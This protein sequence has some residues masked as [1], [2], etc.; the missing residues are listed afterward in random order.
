MLYFK[1][2]IF[3]KIWRLIIEDAERSF[4]RKLESRQVA[5]SFWSKSDRDRAAS[6]SVGGF[7]VA[8]RAAGFAIHEAILAN[9][10]VN[11]RLTEA[12][13]LFALTRALDLLTLRAMDFRGTGSGAHGF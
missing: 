4:V 9:A 3:W 5:G 10:N 2:T 11:H 6:D 12:A 8:R 7:V 13:E 1:E